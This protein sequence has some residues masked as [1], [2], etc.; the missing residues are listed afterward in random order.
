MSGSRDTDGF[1]IIFNDKSRGI[2]LKETAGNKLKKL[3]GRR[4]WGSALFPGCV[5][6]SNGDDRIEFTNVGCLACERRRRKKK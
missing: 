5:V 3:M 1:E 2:Y 4:K 6:Y